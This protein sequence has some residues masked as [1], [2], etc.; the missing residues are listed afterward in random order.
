LAPK[1]KLWKITRIL[2]YIVASL[3][4]IFLF[5]V[6]P[7]FLTNIATTSRFHFHDPNDGKTPQSYGIN[8]HPVEFHASDGILLRGWYIP[9]NSEA[10]GTVI[11]CHGHN[12]TR[13]EML[14][15]AVFAHSLGYNGLLFD[16]RHQ[17]D[18][19]GAVSSIGFWERL[20]A[21]AAMQYA[22]REE[23]AARPV[24]LWGVSM[25]A[26]AALLAA[27]ESP[28]AAAVISDSSFLNFTDVV[29]HHYYLF[30]GFVRWFPP[31]PSFPIADEVIHWSAWR[32][33]F[34]PAEFD[35][36]KA[37]RSIGDRPILFVAVEGD[38]RMPP[39]IAQKLYSDAESPL[40]KLVVLPG[41]RHG[42][43]FKTANQQYEA[44]VANF[45]ASLPAPSS[46]L[47]RDWQPQRWR[48]Q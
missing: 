37:V 36:E 33:N 31:L 25:G 7:W 20:D 9:S 44:A 27:A 26:A 17:G 11:Y 3:V 14:P 40:K 42:E 30:R 35:L 13:I 12:R 1:S 28:D 47:S 19:G 43:G 16:L 22:L 45:L 4:V 2:L 15:M 46:A 6:V 23:K 24:I 34:D 29:R 21:E 48:K 18:S 10:R 39:S 5:G 41:T 8:F 32:A 38:R